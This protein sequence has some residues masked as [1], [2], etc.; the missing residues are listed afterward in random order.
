MKKR[1]ALLLSFVLVLSLALCACGGGEKKETLTGTWTATIEMADALNQEL[2]AG[3]P[4][5]AE[6]LSVESFALPLVLEL[7][8]DGTY[9]MGVDTEAMTATMEKLVDELSVGMKEYLGA[10]LGIEG[11]VDEALAA[12]GISMDELIDEL[13]NEIMNEDAYAEFA[14]EGNYK[15]EDGKLHLSDGLDNEIDPEVY[16]TYELDGDTLTLDAGTEA[17]EDYAEFMFPMTLKRSK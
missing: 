9:S 3:D 10:V 8:E 2:T 15:A 11:D 12:M 14:S 1:I 4:T 5:M 13:K 7:K 17:E 16:N 6:Y